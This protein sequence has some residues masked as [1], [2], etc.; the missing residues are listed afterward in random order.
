MHYHTSQVKPYERSAWKKTRRKM[1]LFLV[2]S[3][4]TY[5]VIICALV[6]LVAC[7]H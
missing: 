4:A 6:R 5:V 3:E 2:T 1:Y 7:S